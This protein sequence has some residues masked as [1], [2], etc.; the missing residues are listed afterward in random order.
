MKKKFLTVFLA[1]CLS[2]LCFGCDD[3]G[4]GGSPSPSGAGTQYV[5]EQGLIIAPSSSGSG[6]VVSSIGTCNIPNVTLP[7]SYR[8]MQIIGIGKAAFLGATSLKS[9]V[10]PDSY[11]EIGERA[12]YNCTQLNTV[13]IGSNSNIS[14]IGARAFYNCKSLTSIRLPSKV[15]RIEENTFSWCSELTDV[16]MDEN[17][18]LEQIS[19]GAFYECEK[20]QRFN[21]SNKVTVIGASAFLDCDSLSYNEHG[22]L[23][24]LGNPSNPYLWLM[25]ASSTV[26]SSAQIKEGC[27]YVYDYALDG[28]ASLSSLILPDSLVVIASTAF[29]GCSALSYNVSENVNYLGNATNPYLLMMS[30]VDKTASEITINENCKILNSYAFLDCTEVASVTIPASVKNI[31]QY[32]FNGCSGLESVTFENPVGWK[33]GMLSIPESDLED[34]ATSARYLTGDY[35]QMRWLND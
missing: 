15:S 23:K 3:T 26:I 4:L 7:T 16:T 17:G 31:G 8:G 9:V 27:K 12:F 10:I 5:N 30:V 34:T 2:L 24:Y 28:C 19:T 14:S 33:I 25:G 21:V 13:S 32:A 22:G 18:A 20:L 1:L 35:W 6:Y 29:R 11:T